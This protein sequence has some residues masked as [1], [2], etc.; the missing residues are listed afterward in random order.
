MANQATVLDQPHGPLVIKDIPVP[1]C[2]PTEV[3]V[4]VRAVATN[5]AD[6][7][8]Y[9][10]HFPQVLPV[11]LGCDVAGEVAEV[12][13]SVVG[14][15]VGDRVAGFTQQQLVGMESMMAIGSVASDLR[16][17]GYQKFVPMLPRMIFKIP[18]SVPN[19]IATTFGCSFFTAAAGVFKSLGFPFPIPEVASVEKVLVWGAASAV[20]AFAVQLLKASHMEVIAVCSAKNFDYI[21]N[22]GASHVI[23]Y[24]GTDVAAQL[25]EQRIR[26]KKAF[27]SISSLETCNACLDIV[28]E[29][30]TVADVQFLEALR[31]PGIGMEHINVVDILG[32]AQ[33]PLLSPL[34]NDWVPNG[35]VAGILKGVQYQIYS[36]GLNS[37]DQAIRDHRDGKIAGKAVITG[38]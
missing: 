4:K 35:L 30:G 19:E 16:H 25:R 6:W 18:E 29:G 11:L 22:L 33:A 32:E 23:D 9:E 15:N 13:R 20:G 26:V 14:L 17:G 36:G 1:Q 21:R 7:K 28:G 37:I 2:H 24:H 3:L 31:R 8:I 12:G 5:A 34:V 27:D 10:G 38:I